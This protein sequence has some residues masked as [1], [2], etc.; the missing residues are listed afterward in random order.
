VAFIVALGRIF[1]GT[2]VSSACCHSFQALQF[3]L[4]VVSLSLFKTIVNYVMVLVHYSKLRTLVTAIFR[5]II[6][7]IFN[8]VN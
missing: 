6:I 2:S 4:P 1:P 3:P 5:S 7:M 8:D